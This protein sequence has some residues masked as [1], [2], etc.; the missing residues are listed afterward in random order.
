[1]MAG[2]RDEMALGESRALLGW[3]DRLK[4]QR[5]EL[6][7][8]LGVSVQRVSDYYKTVKDGTGD[9]IPRNGR[10]V[11]KRALEQRETKQ[12]TTPAYPSERG[13]YTHGLLERLG[14]ETDF[15]GIRWNIV[16]RMI[17]EALRQPK[18]GTT[19]EE[20]SV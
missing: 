17:E 2:R 5:K 11:L 9:A 12:G 6:A 20:G 19:G 15:S 3:A 13:A 10:Q 18:E 1:M 14:K 8:I 16:T 7:A 4:V